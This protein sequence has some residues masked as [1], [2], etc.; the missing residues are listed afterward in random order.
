MPRARISKSIVDQCSPGEKDWVLWDERLS[1][2]GLKVTPAGSKV[3]IF[4]YRMG[5]RGFKVRR[6]TIG[7]HGRVTAEQARKK[8]GSLALEVSN[9]QDPQADRANHRR[10]AVNLAFDQYIKQFNERCLETEWAATHKYAFS[11]LENYAAPIIGST[12]ITAITRRDVNAA[13]LPLAAKPATA[14]NLFAV[15]RRLFSWA[16]EQED[17]DRSPVEGMRPPPLP[18]SRDRVLTDQE[19]GLVWWAA[20]A[21]GYPFGPFVHLLILTGA[22]REEVAG[23][24]WSELDRGSKLWSLPSRRS[25]NAIAADIPLSDLALTVLDSL[26]ATSPDRWPSQGLVLT[27]TGATSISGYSRA[28]RRLDKAVLALTTRLELPTP[29]PW[30][31]H[32]LRRTLATGLQKQGVRLEVTEA[33]LNHVS[34]SRRGIVGVYQRYNW[35]DEKRVALQAWADHVVRL[36]EALQ[37]IDQEAS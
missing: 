4:Q 15:L 32:D 21:L 22:R 31:L 20:D 19:L 11:L 12:P 1:G 34:G 3:Y 5:G 10:R 36:P 14:S 17:I 35:Q 9:G 2:F 29:K 23:L 13:L 24:D 26:A 18:P 33:V 6:Y 25:K 27:T 28:K 30:R 16:I 8:A 37:N 7:K